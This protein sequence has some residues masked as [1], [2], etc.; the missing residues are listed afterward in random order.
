MESKEKLIQELHELNRQYEEAYEENRALLLMID[1]AAKGKTPFPSQASELPA[2]T[3]NAKRKFNSI[4]AKRQETM[5]K[6][7][8]LYGKGSVDYTV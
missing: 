8:K 5:D 3:A 4:T 1:D 6:L 7:H 2:K